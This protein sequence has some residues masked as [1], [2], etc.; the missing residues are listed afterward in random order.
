[1]NR[2]KGAS[3]GSKNDGTQESKEKKEITQRNDK[4]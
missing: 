1:M 2:R 4:K 3:K